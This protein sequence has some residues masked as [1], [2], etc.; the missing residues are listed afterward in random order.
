MG[1]SR[2]VVV[3]GATRGIGRSL[4]EAFLARGCSLAFCGRDAAGVDALVALAPDRLAGLVADVARYDDM[5]ALWELAS[6]RF[7]AVDVWINNAGTSNPQTP[8]VTLAPPVIEAVVSANMLGTMNGSRVALEGMM[9]QGHGALYLMEGYGSDGERAP[10]M[11]LYGSTKI[12]VRYLWRSLA[13]EAKG[14]GVIVGA[15]SP[16]V[17]PTD[18]LRSVYE[19]GDPRRWRRQRWLFKFIADPAE[20]VCPWLADRVLTN[21]RSGRRIA[22]MTVAKAALRFF[23]PRYHRRDLFSPRSR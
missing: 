22:W 20:V 16:G 19:Q 23:L 11:A 12:A 2:C 3:T 17:V 8:F 5:R 1:A 6:S 4:V 18:L 14:T 21:R 7:G 15:L 10:G 13:D 9:R